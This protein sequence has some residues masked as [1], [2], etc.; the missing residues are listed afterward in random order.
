[1]VHSKD[2]PNLF[3][4]DALPKNLQRMNRSTKND[5]FSLQQMTRD[6]D[7]SNQLIAD[8]LLKVKMG[9]SMEGIHTCK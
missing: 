3:M 6:K 9:G 7:I 8:Y 4:V 5:L 2:S 1:M